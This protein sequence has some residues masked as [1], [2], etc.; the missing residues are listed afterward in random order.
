MFSYFALPYDLYSD[1]GLEFINSV[2]VD[3]IDIQPGECKIVI[4]KPRSLWVQ[5]CVEKV[6][7]SVEMVIIAKQHEVTSDD[8]ST[9][10][11]EIQSA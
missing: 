6:N 2:I 4:G 9:C 11:P 8:W 10:L 1:N 5:R 7:H 3:T